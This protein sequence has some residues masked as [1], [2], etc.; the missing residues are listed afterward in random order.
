MRVDLKGETALLEELNV[1]GAWLIN[2]I[3]I[4][5]DSR[6]FRQLTSE[7]GDWSS[8]AIER[9]L[10]KVTHVKQFFEKEDRFVIY[11]QIQHW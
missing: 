5:D 7:A 1:I 4:V 2:D 6:S 9:I 11:K 8:V 3:I 10:D